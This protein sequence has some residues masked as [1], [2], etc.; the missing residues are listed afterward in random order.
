M[1]IYIYKY[2]LS[3]ICI[4]VYI[5][6]CS[7]YRL[8]M[9]C[10]QWGTLFHVFATINASSSEKKDPHSANTRRRI[11]VPTVEV[12]G[13]NQIQTSSYPPFN[14]PILRS[15]KSNKCKFPT[16]LVKNR[17]IKP[18]MMKTGWTHWKCMFHIEE[19]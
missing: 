16:G 12:I 17:D 5:Y 9:W 3:Y 6:I 8:K 18:E 10:Y 15:Q 7:I 4:K 1:Y 14:S 13:D 2:I 11:R 19:L